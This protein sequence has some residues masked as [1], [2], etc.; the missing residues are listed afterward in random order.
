M[1]LTTGAATLV[2]AIGN[3]LAARDIAVA[4]AT[5]VVTAVRERTDLATA[6]GLYPNPATRHYC[7][8]SRWPAPASVEL[9]VFDN[10]GRRVATSARCGPARRRPTP[11]AGM[12]ARA[13]PGLYFVRLA[14]DGQ[15]AAT[16]QLVVE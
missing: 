9:S 2:G 13:K 12:P 6:F 10:L 5:G 1:N 11:C 7:W 14:V 4:G 16:R 15:P 8:P 3:G